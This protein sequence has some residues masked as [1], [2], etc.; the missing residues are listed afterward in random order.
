MREAKWQ[1][2]NDG[3]DEGEWL[4]QK[5]K[6]GERKRQKKIRRAEMAKAVERMEAEAHNNKVERLMAD[7]E[8]DGEVND[9]FIGAVEAERTNQTMA[10]NF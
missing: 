4:T 8:K 3:E 2:N 7:V 10:M 5:G 1:K 9:V 6:Q